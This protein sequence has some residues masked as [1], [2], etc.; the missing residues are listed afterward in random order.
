MI[1]P[2]AGRATSKMLKAQRSDLSIAP[3]TSEEAPATCARIVAS[4]PGREQR[5]MN[6]ARTSYNIVIGSADSC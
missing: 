1:L 4:G 2:E 3:G 5:D 6:F